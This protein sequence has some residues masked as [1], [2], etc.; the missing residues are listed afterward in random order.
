M[1][2]VEISGVRVDITIGELEVYRSPLWWIESLRGYP[3]GRAG[4]TLPDPEGELHET[5]QLG[6]AVTIEVGYRDQDPVMWEGTVSQIY[7]GATRDEIEVRAIDSARLLTETKVIQ[8]WENE[9][10]EAIVKW[11]LTQTGLPI[12]E[13]DA[14]AVTIPRFIS[15]NMPVWQ[16]V[17][18]VMETCERAF[19]LD[20]SRRALWLGSDGVNWSDG[21]EPGEIPIIATMDNLIRH[22]P[23]TPGNTTPWI[24][25]ILMAEL[26]HSR[27]IRL[28]DDRRGIDAEIRA[29]RVRHEGTP[30]HVRTFIWY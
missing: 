29:Q 9:S 2:G 17:R 10:P 19:G 7:P 21:D 12:G 27:R 8:S 15:S 13:L 24:E 30:E 14:S 11:A 26:S 23:A 1:S 22:E 25:T 3:L 20:M 18:Q 16:L 28:Q 6:D 5:I 4:V